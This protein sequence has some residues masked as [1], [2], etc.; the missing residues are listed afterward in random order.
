MVRIKH[1]NQFAAV[2]SEESCPLCSQLYDL[3]DHI[4]THITSKLYCCRHCFLSTSSIKILI[5][6]LRGGK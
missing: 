1:K 4:K 3:G 5:K 2:K 6:Q